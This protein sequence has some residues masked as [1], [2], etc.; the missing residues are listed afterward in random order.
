MHEKAHLRARIEAGRHLIEHSDLVV[1]YLDPRSPDHESLYLPLLDHAGKA[2]S[3][4]WVIHAHAPQNAERKSGEGSAARL[5]DRLENFN[6]RLAQSSFAPDE[7]INK[8]IRNDPGR[9]EAVLPSQGAAFIKERLLPV[10]AA[11]EQEAVRFQK[12]YRRTGLLAFILSFLSAAMV[13]VGVTFFHA[14]GWVFLLESLL[15]ATI[16]LAIYRANRLHS[17]KNWME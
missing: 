5:I 13:A 9:F 3:P 7:Q 1:F 17:H 6:R 12:I 11:A 2:G 4:F 14:P 15:L 10:F 8:L 16:L